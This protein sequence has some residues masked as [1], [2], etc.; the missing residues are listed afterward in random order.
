MSIKRASL[1]ASVALASFVVYDPSD[2]ID[3]AAWATDNALLANY[4]IPFV[5]QI[6]YVQLSTSNL[7]TTPKITVQGIPN[8][9]PTE[10]H[11][12]TA[13]VQHKVLSVDKNDTSVVVVTEG[14]DVTFNYDTFIKYGYSSNLLEGRGSHIPSHP[15]ITSADYFQQASME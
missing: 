11:G 15:I 5:S 12:E 1:F 10:F 7:L 9:A 3:P 4:S 2:V 13:I 8:V 14:S 6:S